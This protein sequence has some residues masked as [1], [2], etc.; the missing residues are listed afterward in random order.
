[1]TGQH[2]NVSRARHAL[3]AFALVGGTMAAVAG[4]SQSASADS[5]DQLVVVDVTSADSRTFSASALKTVN[6]DGTKSFAKP[7][8]LPVGRRRTGQRL[9]AR[10]RLQRQRVLGAQRRRE[11]SCGRRIPPHAR[12]DRPGQEQRCRQAQGHEDRGLRRRSRRPAHGRADRERRHRQHV[13]PFSDTA[14]N[15]AHPRGVATDNGSSFYVSGNDGSTDTGVFTVPL[16]GGAR[17]PIAGVGDRGR[18]RPEEH[19]E[20]PDRWRRPL[21]GLGEDDAGRSG[22]DRLRVCR[23]LSPRSPG[24]APH[25]DR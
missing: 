4:T 22:Q 11:L 12:S 8:D 25:L 19:P 15:E 21:H 17:T 16:G 2:L 9:R 7:V 14:L 10:R 24:W 5:S 20:C 13:A 23:P 1:M 6:A 3:V 18:R